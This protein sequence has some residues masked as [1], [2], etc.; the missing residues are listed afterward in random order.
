LFIDERDDVIENVIKGEIVTKI[1]KC[2]TKE[3]EEGKG[4]GKGQDVDIR[5][6]VDMD[7]YTNKALKQRMLVMK[8]RHFRALAFKLYCLIEDK[9]AGHITKRTFMQLALK[10]N[11]LVL[12]PPVDMELAAIHASNDWDKDSSGCGYVEFDNFF[13][14]I[15]QLCDM[16]TSGCHVQEYINMLLKIMEGITVRDEGTGK[17]IFKNDEAVKFLKFFNFLGDIEVKKFELQNDPHGIDSSNYHKHTGVGLK[18]DLHGKTIQEA[19]L[20]HSVLTRGVTV[21]HIGEDDDGK[22]ASENAKKVILLEK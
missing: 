20:R 5:K 9:D 21:T 2:Y 15:F 16:W 18:T 7:T 3:G 6:Q 14:G 22:Q 19:E 10:I 11:L 12:P 13:K 4:K 17:I 8:D 1:T